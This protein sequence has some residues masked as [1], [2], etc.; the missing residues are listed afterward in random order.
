MGGTEP[1]SWVTGRIG[2]I[3]C[4]ID[5]HKANCVRGSHREPDAEGSHS[6]SRS[7]RTT[8]RFCAKWLQRGGAWLSTAASIAAATGG[9]IEAIRPAC[10]LCSAAIASSGWFSVGIS[11][12]LERQ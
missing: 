6:G 2:D 12:S 10:S 4:R 7:S 11:F 8:Q 1:H 5:G 9:D 3:T